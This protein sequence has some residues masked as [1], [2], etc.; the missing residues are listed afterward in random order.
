M[1][2]ARAIID[3]ADALEQHLDSLGQKSLLADI[4]LPVMTV[5]GEMERDGIAVD[6]DYLDDLQSTFAAEVARSPPRPLMPRS[7]G[8]STS[9]RPSSC[10]WCCSTSW[11]CPRPSAPRPGTPPTPMRWSAC[12]S[13]PATRSSPTCCGTGTSPGSRHGRGAAQVGRRRRPDPHHLPADRGRDRPAVEHRTEPAEHPDPHRRGPADP[14]RFCSRTARRP[15][16]H[17]GLLADRDADH[18]HPVR[19]RRA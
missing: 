5:L 7:A 10:R 1:V 3:L 13:R 11:A 16:A 6:I 17:R 12:T 4:E 14:A 2:K 15:A 18:G 19:G 8:R 9:A